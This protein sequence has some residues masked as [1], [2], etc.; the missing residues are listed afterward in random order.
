M[1][2]VICQ[3]ER[4]LAEKVLGTK[5]GFGQKR[6]H[7]LLVREADAGDEG[8]SAHPC[9]VLQG[10]AS[11]QGAASEGTESRNGHKDEE[12]HKMMG[13]PP[14]INGL[15]HESTYLQNWASKGVATGPGMQAESLSTTNRDRLTAIM[16]SRQMFAKARLR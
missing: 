16:K 7:R 8:S 10:A 5:T 1:R 4:R 14:E 6:S 11:V 13:G 3:G 9:R 15:L 2:Q 12:T